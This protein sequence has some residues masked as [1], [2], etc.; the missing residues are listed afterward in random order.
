MNEAIRKVGVCV[1]CRCLIRSGTGSWKGYDSGGSGAD[2]TAGEFERTPSLVR[3][4][5]GPCILPSHIAKV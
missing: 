3:F 1:S 2:V 4:C 5:A